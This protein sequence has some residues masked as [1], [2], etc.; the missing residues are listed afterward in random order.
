MLYCTQLGLAASFLVLVCVGA[1]GVERLGRVS[2]RILTMHKVRGEL[3]R[4]SLVKDSGMAV[5][6]A[7]S[8]SEGRFQWAD[9]EP[10]H[11]KVR[12]EISLAPVSADVTVVEG[13][14]PRPWS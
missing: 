8:D 6:A 9:I 4:V 10:G 7:S 2:G 3:C 1:S 12:A 5:Q 14:A 11:Y 13:R